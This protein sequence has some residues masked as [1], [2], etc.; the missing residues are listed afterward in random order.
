MNTTDC[1]RA[2][3]ALMAVLDGESDPQSA[4]GREHL[5]TC[6]SC[7]RWF[8]D[9]QAVTGRLQRLSYRDA[10]VDLWTAVERGIHRA[11]RSPALPPRL[12]TIGIAV[13]GW[14]AVQLFVDLPAP[15]LHPL[16]PLVAIVAALWL[17][18]GDPLAIQTSAPELEK[19]GI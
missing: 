12:W 17:A 4:A 1:E 11:G 16:V 18:A 8:E 13:L 7:A 14:R 6:A 15:E 3:V 2:R 10:P 9:L 5:S 19:R